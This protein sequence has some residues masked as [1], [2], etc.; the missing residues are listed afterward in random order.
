[1]PDS[2][3]LQDPWPGGTDSCLRGVPHAQ[4]KK[5][6]HLGP[7]SVCLSKRCPSSPRFPCL[8]L[9]SQQ[10]ATLSISVTVAATCLVFLVYEVLSWHVTGLSHNHL[11]GIE[12]Q[13]AAGTPPGSWTYK[14]Q[15]ISSDFW[16]NL[17]SSDPRCPLAFGGWSR[18]C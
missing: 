5:Q 2:G 18:G 1:M 9:C 12:A 3:F 11:L 4:I 14:G 10:P 16:S 13:G 7:L 15:S 17:V 6:L 8:S